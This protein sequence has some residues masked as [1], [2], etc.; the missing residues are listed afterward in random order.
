M[1]SALLRER[2]QPLRIEEVEATALGR[3]EV[4]VKIAGTGICHTDLTAIDGT[5]PF[6]LPADWLDVHLL[7]LTL[8]NG[9]H[10]VSDVSFS[11]RPGSLTAIIGPSG[12][13]K[14][15]LAKLVA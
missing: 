3:D 6:P 4:L 12:A 15:T 10:L 14:S 9:R 13:G 1:R 5:V 11:A 7:G 8:P 2:S